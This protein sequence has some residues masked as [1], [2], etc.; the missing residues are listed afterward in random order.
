[1]VQYP[2]YIFKGDF[3]E[4]IK[5]FPHCQIWPS[6]LR[7]LL[8]SI[9]PKYMSCC[10]LKADL[11]KPCKSTSFFWLQLLKYFEENV[12]CILGAA[13]GNFLFTTDQT[14][15]GHTSFGRKNILIC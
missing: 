9:V 2:L 11:G 15:G 6:Y 3:S 10:K 12:K 5:R 4:I 1:M 7:Y 13:F 14:S 8:F